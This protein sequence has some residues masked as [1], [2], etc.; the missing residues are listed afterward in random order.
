MRQLQLGTFRA[1][2]NHHRPH[3][4][5]DGPTPITAFNARLKAQPAGPDPAVRYPVRH[6]RE[7]KQ[8]RVIGEDGSLLRELVLDPARDCQPLGTPCSR[9]KLGHY[10]VRQMP[11]IT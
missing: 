4:A 2:H 6:D 8:G 1:Y 5:L 7:D 11:T 10:D 3:R 9:P